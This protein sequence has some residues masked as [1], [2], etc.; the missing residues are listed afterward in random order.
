MFNFIDAIKLGFQNYFKFK[1]RST[2]S[3]YWWWVLF[4]V[5]AGIPLTL[6]DSH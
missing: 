1:G 4:I 5:L 3:E 6:I 2:R